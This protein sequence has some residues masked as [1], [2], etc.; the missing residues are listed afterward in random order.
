LDPAGLT[1]LDDVTWRI[2]RT[3]A[4]RVPVV[5]YAGEALVRGMDDKVAEQA[6]NVATLPGIA[7]ACY[8]MP[9]GHWGYGFPIGGV[10]PSTRTR[11][12][13]YP[14]VASASTSPAAFAP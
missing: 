12:A 10:P 5:I 2:E 11:A 13:S 4:M 9:D 3:G 8:V 7:G 1:K 6:S 14:P